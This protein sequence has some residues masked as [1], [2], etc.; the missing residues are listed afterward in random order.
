M[1]QQSNK[2]RRSWGLFIRNNNGDGQ[3]LRIIDYVTDAE[4][5]GHYKWV[6]YENWWERSSTPRADNPKL[7]TIPTSSESWPQACRIFGSCNGPRTMTAL[8]DQL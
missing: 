5:N 4:G 2:Y 6:A 8:I 1:V 7:S 3:F